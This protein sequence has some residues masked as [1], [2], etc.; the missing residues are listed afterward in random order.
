MGKI[1]RIVQVERQNIEKSLGNLF[2]IK[3][4]EEKIKKLEKQNEALE[5]S[6]QSMYE[7]AVK[8]LKIHKQLTDSLQYVQRM[9][10]AIL[11]PNTLFTQSFEEHFILY[12]PKDIVSGDF[13]W[14]SQ[15]DYTFLAVVDCTGHGVPGAFMSMIGNTLLNEIINVKRQNDPALILNF[16]HIGIRNALNQEETKNHDGMDMGLCRLERDE[17]FDLKLTYAGAKNTML[18]YQKATQSFQKITGNRTHIGGN[19]KAQLQFDNVE[20]LLEEG[21]VFYM[22]TDGVVDA[23]DA[24]R[25]SFGITRILEL[26]TNYIHTPLPTQGVMLKETIESYQSQTHQRDDITVLGIKP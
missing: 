9:Q 6:Q 24:M 22:M 15:L 14:F 26:L 3:A 21:D 25:R 23:C 4:L 5:A 10:K 8:F 18:V 13:Y 12:Q 2:Y 19:D 17:N 1:Q 20:F 7:N 11:P 16:L